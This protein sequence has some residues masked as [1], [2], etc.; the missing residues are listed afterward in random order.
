[1]SQNLGFEEEYVRMALVQ[2]NG[3]I[4]FAAEILFQLN[5]KTMRAIRKIE[6]QKKKNFDSDLYSQIFGCNVKEIKKKWKEQIIENLS[7]SELRSLARRQ[8]VHDDDDDDE[9]SDSET[10]SFSDSAMNESFYKKH[11]NEI[12]TLCQSAISILFLLKLY[13]QFKRYKGRKNVYFHVFIDSFLS[14]Y[15]MVQLLNDFE[16]LHIFHWDHCELFEEFEKQLGECTICHCLSFKRHFRDRGKY[17]KDAKRY[18]LYNLQQQQDEEEIMKK[19]IVCLQIMDEIHCYLMHSLMKFDEEM[20]ESDEE[21][22]EYA[23]TEFS[24]TAGTSFHSPSNSNSKTNLSVHYDRNSTHKTQQKLINHRLMMQRKE[25]LI[26]YGYSRSYGR[27]EQKNDDAL[28]VFEWQS[29]VHASM[30]IKP[31]FNSMK[32]EILNNPYY[33]L[34]LCEYNELWYKTEQIAKTWIRKK[35]KAKEKFVGVIGIEFDAKRQKEKEM[36]L[37]IKKGDPIALEFIF[38]IKLYTDYDKLQYELKKCLRSDKHSSAAKSGRHTV[39]DLSYLYWWRQ[40]ILICVSKYGI[41]MKKHKFFYGCQSRME[42]ANFGGF[43]LFNGPLSMTIS[44]E[45]AKQFGMSKAL[46]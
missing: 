31:H 36:R 1:M 3:D 22:T 7:K 30:N 29:T 34:S 44:L 14:H 46:C 2:S 4:A 32:E 38:A 23:E 12:P 40:I 13:E 45:V 25:E 27:G 21:E 5:D 18:K 37:R 6:K 42:F 43:G 19:E 28:N 11:K 9:H 15:S 39:N 8:C 16:H 33:K 41:K 35:I 24:K 10:E 26:K 20:D 17:K